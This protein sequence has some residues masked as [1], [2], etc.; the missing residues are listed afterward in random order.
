ME[1]P[2]CVC[3]GIPEQAL[4]LKW[5]SLGQAGDYVFKGLCG[6]KRALVRIKGE[7]ESGW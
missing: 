7:D 3:R 6:N 5:A 2:Q 4:A 1:N